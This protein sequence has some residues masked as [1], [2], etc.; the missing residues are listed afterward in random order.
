MTELDGQV[1]YSIDITGTASVRVKIIEES[2]TMVAEYEG[3][4]GK[5]IIPNVRLWE[6]LDAYLYTPRRTGSRR[7][8]D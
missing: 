1:Q 5:M 3:Q 7:R 6:P 8:N 4:S 2:G